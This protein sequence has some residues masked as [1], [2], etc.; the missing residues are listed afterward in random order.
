MAK[1]Q[2]VVRL[3]VWHW[4]GRDRVS[5]QDLEY[6]VAASSREE[7]RQTVMR[8]H[9]PDWRRA[10]TLKEDD[11]RHQAAATAPGRVFWRELGE[12]TGWRDEAALEEL[13]RSSTTKQ[14]SAG[15]YTEPVHR[16]DGR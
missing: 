14:L 2:F 6:L 16:P 13:R 4:D 1:R 11:P 9:L 10:R 3:S 12:V 5:L 15:Q 7:W 8:M